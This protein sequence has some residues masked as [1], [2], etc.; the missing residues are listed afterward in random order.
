MAKMTKCKTCGHEV[1]TTAKRCPNCGAKLKMG[2]F[3]KALIGI[4]AIIVIA[5]IANAAGGGNKNT[6]SPSTNKTTTPSTGTN[7]KEAPKPL[8][9]TGVSSDV[10]I[11]VNGVDT[12]S[13][14]GG[15]YANEKAQGVFKIVNV[16]VTNNQKDA[17]T[18][19]ANSFKLVDDKG[20]QFTYSSSGQT[21]LGMTDNTVVDFFLKQLNPGLTQTGKIVFDVPTDAKGLTMKAR[22]GMTGD[23][24]T[25]KVE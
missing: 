15:Q 2:F 16:S 6:T 25:L 20:R 4:G 8:S 13:D 5:I 9:N 18:L 23:E 12:K 14:V 17:I 3:K 21:A 1:S 24:I 10:T 19:D 7:T 22:G 11:T